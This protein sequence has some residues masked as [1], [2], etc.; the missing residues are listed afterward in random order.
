MSQGNTPR[1]SKPQKS[2]MPMKLDAQAEAQ[3]MCRQGKELVSLL[4]KIKKGEY[5]VI[6]GNFAGPGVQKYVVA[7]SASVFKNKKQK[8]K[9]VKRWPD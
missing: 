6:W 8:K 1:S 2:Y 5:E 3:E 9:Y 4:M 7:P